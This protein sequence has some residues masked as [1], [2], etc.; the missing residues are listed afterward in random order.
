[1]QNIEKIARARELC[2]LGFNT[3]SA[4]YYEQIDK[5]LSEVVQTEAIQKA[6]RLCAAGPTLSSPRF[7]YPH[8]ESAISG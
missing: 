1:M 3:H 6:R 8:I 5:I 7:A 2:Q 4:E